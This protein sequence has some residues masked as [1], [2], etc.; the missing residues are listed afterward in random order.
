MIIELKE[1]GI[2]AIGR[3]V[4]IEELHFALAQPGGLFDKNI[5]AGERANRLREDRAVPRVGLEMDAK[6][7][8][9]RPGLEARREGKNERGAEQTPHGGLIKGLTAFATLGLF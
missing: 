1:H 5:F 9:P 2:A 3:A 6:R 8:L 4:W 7:A